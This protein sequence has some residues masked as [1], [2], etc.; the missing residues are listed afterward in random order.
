MRVGAQVGHTGD[1]DAVI[2]ACTTVDKCVGELLQTV[3]EMGGRWLVA[4]DHGNSDDMVQVPPPPPPPLPP[5]SPPS[6]L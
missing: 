5:L 6:L 3:D 2:R 1:L 4:S